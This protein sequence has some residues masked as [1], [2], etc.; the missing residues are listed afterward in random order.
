MLTPDFV[1]RY[2]EAT[3][4]W[5]PLGEIIY[6]RT[7]SRWLEEEG[8]RERWHETNQRWVNFSASLAPNHLEAGELETL[9]D[10]CW[11]LKAFP[12]GRTLWSAGTGRGAANFNCC[13]TSLHSEQSFYDMVY[14]LMSGAGV[15]VRITQDR[16][17][18]LEQSLPLRAE[19]AKLILEPYRYVGQPGLREHSYSTVL[20]GGRMARLVVGDSREGWAEAVRDFLQLLSVDSLEEIRINLDYVRPL[21]TRLRTFGGYAS[22][23][24]P[25]AELFLDSW[26]ALLHGRTRF[27]SSWQPDLL[28]GLSIDAQQASGMN[29]LYSDFTP[30]WT[31]LKALDVA[32][33]IGRTVVSGGVRRSAIIALGDSARFADAKT[34]SWFRYAPW[35]SQS[36][37]T[38][39][40]PQKPSREELS[41]LLDLILEYG[42]PGFLNE[43]SALQRR[44]DFAGINP[45]AEILLAERGTCNLCTVNLMAFRK[46]SGVDREGLAQALRTITRHAVRITELDLELP[47]W[48]Q[49]QK[50]DRLLGISFTG[51]G[52]LVDATGMDLHSQGE[53][54]RW[55]REVVL[56]S[57]QEYAR[58]LGI[59]QPVLSTTVKPEGTLSLLAGVSSGLHPSFGPY[60]LRR[61]QIAQSDAVAQALDWLGFPSEPSI[62]ASHTQVFSFPVATPARRYASEYGAVEMLERYRLIMQ[63]YVQHNASITVYL[64]PEEKEAVV[65]W[66]L[67]HWDEYVAV[68][69]LPKNPHVYPQAP[70]QPISKEEYQ[71]ARSR[72]PR[73][74]RAVLEELERGQ[75]Q[76]DANLELCDSGA[77]PVR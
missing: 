72:L 69:F 48:D 4:P 16:I 28:Q 77:C 30:G 23:P 14:L 13:F 39:V 41:R 18:S 50:K 71:Q 25:L 11:N 6:L 62:Y 12:A 73:F 51:Y 17:R 58:Q 24:M 44:S 33:M 57:A 26:L 2:A 40:L 15:G 65:E 59:P 31:D 53:L 68:S 61:V 22:G 5:G 76:A 47:L 29:C 55:M 21:G 52:D 32:N 8:R 70:Y 1:H 19:R 37:N 43:A 49:Q 35:R 45:C 46:G 9:F 42:E 20:D 27:G 38:L 3:P 34:G 56:Q 60:F 36:N 67:E 63:S 66:L 75:M 10:L 74:S 54:L 7:Y 64:A